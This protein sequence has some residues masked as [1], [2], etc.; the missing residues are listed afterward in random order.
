MYGESP[1]TDLKIEEKL[2]ELLNCAC[3]LKDNITARI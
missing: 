1:P 3:P 2:K